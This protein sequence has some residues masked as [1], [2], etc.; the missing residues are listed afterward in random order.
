MKTIRLRSSLAKK[1][2]YSLYQEQLK[3]ISISL[4]AKLA[5]G[6]VTSPC[7]YY[8]YHNYYYYYS[9]DFT[10]SNS[11]IFLLLILN[12]LGDRKISQKKNSNTLVDAFYYNILN[13]LHRCYLLHHHIPAKLY[14]SILQAVERK[15]VIINDYVNKEKV[16]GAGN[17]SDLYFSCMKPAILVRLMMTRSRVVC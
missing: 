6:T 17:A 1:R 9:C 2:N 3:N 16:A 10:G 4:N 5:I 13:Y 11:I 14:F 7:N 8:Y 15:A 12:F